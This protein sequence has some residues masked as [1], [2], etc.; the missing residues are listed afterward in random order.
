MTYDLHGKTDSRGDLAFIGNGTYGVR[1]RQILH[2]LLISVSLRSM[3][4]V[5]RTFFRRSVT[6][7]LIRV[8]FSSTSLASWRRREFCRRNQ[9]NTNEKH[10]K[11]KK[12]HKA[13]EKANRAACVQ[14]KETTWEWRPHD[15]MLC[16]RTS[17]HVLEPLRVH[18]VMQCIRL[19]EMISPSTGVID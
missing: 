1:V 16:G 19:R 10:K 7:S 15:I 2:N 6:H 13:G 9:R 3:D 14:W 17:T 5:K 11:G 4:L 18:G 12:K 8:A